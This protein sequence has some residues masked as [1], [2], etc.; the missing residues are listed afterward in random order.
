MDCF[1]MPYGKYEKPHLEFRLTQP[2]FK[3]KYALL[4][5]IKITRLR[6]YFT[7]FIAN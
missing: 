4:H 7:Y 2:V 1:S 6:V 5:F 3:I